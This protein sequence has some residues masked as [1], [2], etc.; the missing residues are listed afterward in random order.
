ME[1]Q[2]GSDAFADDDAGTQSEDESK[3]QV[4]LQQQ[5]RL[6]TLCMIMIQHRW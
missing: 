5:P 2:A 1:I 6:P 4:T 3:S